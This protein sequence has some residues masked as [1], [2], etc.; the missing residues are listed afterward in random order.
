MGDATNSFQFLLDYLCRLE[1]HKI[2][3]RLA[4]IRDEAIMVLVSVPGEHWEV[5]FFADGSVE[6]EIFGSSG[7]VLSDAEA[8]ESLERLIADHGD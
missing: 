5:E 3:Y 8:R 7:S 4:H 6:V 1:K 2:H